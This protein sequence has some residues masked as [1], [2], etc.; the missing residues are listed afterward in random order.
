MSER[1]TRNAVVV[2]AGIGGL[3]AA[4]GL[5]KAGWQAMVL[6]RS[7]PPAEVG[8]GLSLWANALAALD[9]LGVGA[10]VRSMATPQVS[11]GIRTST[12]RWLSRLGNTRRLEDAGVTLLMVHRTELHRE[13]L[14]A[15]PASTVVGGAAVHSVSERDDQV[16]VGYHTS[17]GP[18]EVS[19]DLVV[20]AD[21]IHSTM[22]DALWPG[23]AGPV[24]AG[25]TAWRGVTDK[26]F[27]LRGLASENWG[28]GAEFG[29]IPLGD[30]RV[31]WF[32]TANLPRASGFPD[33]Y[34]EVLRRF[35]GWADP[36]PEVIRATA[37]E[38]VLRH[39]LHH[40]PLPLS[41]FNRGRVALLGDAAHAQTPH[42]GQGAC[43][44][45]EDAAVL[46]AAVGAD[47]DVPRA[48]ER[49][50]R[51]RR[52]RTERLVAGSARLGRII[53]L[54]NP[55]ALA[56]RNLAIR[57]TPMRATLAG[58]ARITSWTPPTIRHPAH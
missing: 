16:V 55:T 28:T 25:C 30:Q 37:P 9:A 13:L 54:E 36:I 34:A 44:A 52:H 6:E 3:A 56:L 50:D 58:V 57:A 31:Y 22:R 21:G 39:D 4:I 19:A 8:A 11:G 29:L 5:R 48:L 24:Y 41:R 20:G 17:R 27:D 35:A 53:Q 38:A 26:P 14:A 23:A 10:T 32:G 18:A 46:A 12:G 40:L 15:L 33:E 43:L 7:D 47:P 2:G 49:Y 42:L 45:F 51:Q 1:R